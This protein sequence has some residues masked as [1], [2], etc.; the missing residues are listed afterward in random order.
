MVYKKNKN[1]TEIIGLPG[2]GKTEYLTKNLERLNKRFDIIKSNKHTYLQQIRY[3]IVFY[4]SFYSSLKSIDDKSFIKKISYR[5]SFR[6]I[7]NNRKKLFYDSGIFQV[8]LENLIESDFK[9]IEKKLIFLEKFTLPSNLIL[10][11]DKID[12]IVEREIKRKNRRFKFN[13][14]ELTKRYKK[15]LE[16]IKKKIFPMVNSFQTII[17]NN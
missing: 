3:L 11:H 17:V 7:L 15:G 5:I 14:T 1:W 16:I 2:V 6:P 4:S 13:K 12:K 8:L 10:V 9:E